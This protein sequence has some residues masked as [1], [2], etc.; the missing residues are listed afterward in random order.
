VICAKSSARRSQASHERLIVAD[1]NHSYTEITRIRGQPIVL[2]AT[3]GRQDEPPLADDECSRQD[4]QA[5]RGIF[6]G[7]N[8]I[9]S[10]L[11]FGATL[12]AASLIPAGSA[13]TGVAA[14]SKLIDRTLRCTIY[15]RAG[16]RQIE[17]AAQPGIRD[18]ANPSEWTRSPSASAVSYGLPNTPYG[19]LAALGAEAVS[20]NRTRCVSV[21][22]RVALRATGLSGGEPSTFGDEWDCTAPRRVL[23]RLRAVFKEPVRLRLDWTDSTRR[24]REMIARGSL[25]TGAFVIRTEVGRPIAYAAVSASGTVRLFTGD[26]CFP[27]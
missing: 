1:N 9:R 25:Q 4:P 7:M 12:A 15:L 26:N 5:P 16:I 23:V 21:R 11:V 6:S 8:A 10:V 22:T 20:H 19:G 17:L 24:H 14:P 2:G 3:V 13:V 27:D 18:G